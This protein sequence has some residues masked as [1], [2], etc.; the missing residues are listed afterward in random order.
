MTDVPEDQEPVQAPQGSY[1]LCEACGMFIPVDADLCPE[2]GAAAD[3]DE[4]PLPNSAYHLGLSFVLGLILL[5]ALFV[6]SRD[7]GEARR[8]E[9]EQFNRL[10]T[11]GGTT[12]VPGPS[13]TPV[14]ATPTPVP[15]PTA[16][17]IPFNPGMFEATPTPRPP[18]TP[19]P[20]TP[21][22]KRSRTLELKDELSLEYTRQLDENLPIAKMESFVR[23]TLTDGQVHS[24]TIKGQSPQGLLLG[25]SEGQV[26]L[27]FRQLVPESR[28][29]VDAS[30]RASWVEEKTLQEVLRRLRTP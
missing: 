22:P 21:T 4:A 5:S 23:L 14:P 9:L 27:D 15:K 19:P 8:V 28:L 6:L 3:E 13:P 7:R 29:R 10:S 11:A 26:W 25:S 20:P 2:C 16:T 30:A 17:S 12:G 18:P 24:G 1:R